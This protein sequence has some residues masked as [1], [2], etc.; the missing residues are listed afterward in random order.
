MRRNAYMEK[1]ED[2]CAFIGN[3]RVLDDDAPE[4]SSS[5]VTP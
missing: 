5:N 1:S 3:V 2:V 4:K